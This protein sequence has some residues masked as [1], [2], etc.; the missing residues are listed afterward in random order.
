MNKDK[1][2]ASPTR[3]SHGRGGNRI[4]FLSHSSRRKFGRVRTGLSRSPRQ[5]ELYG[6]AAPGPLDISVFEGAVNE[7]VRRH[8]VLRTIFPEMRGTRPGNFARTA[9]GCAGDR[10][11]GSSRRSTRGRGIRIAA[12]ETPLFDLSTGPL[13]DVKALKM[14][15]QDHILLG[16]YAPVI[17]GWLVERRVC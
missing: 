8:E 3:I 17:C 12:N 10:P 16:H 2:E 9:A 7:V 5:H 14:S 15:E 6:S 13:V 11:A 4:L 1:A